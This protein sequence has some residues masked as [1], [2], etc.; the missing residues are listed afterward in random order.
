MVDGLDLGTL[1]PGDLE[2]ASPH[3]HNV[4]KAIIFQSYNIVLEPAVLSQP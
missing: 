1:G 3:W 2:S 4:A